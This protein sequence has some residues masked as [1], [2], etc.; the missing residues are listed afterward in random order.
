MCVHFV[1]IKLT[2]LLNLIMQV[3]QAWLNFGT[4]CSQCQSYKCN[5]DEIIRNF[6]FN[7]VTSTFILCAFISV[8]ISFTFALHCGT[9]HSGTDRLLLPSILPAASVLALPA[10]PVALWFFDLHACCWACHGPRAGQVLINGSRTSIV[11][12]CT[13]GRSRSKWLLS[14]AAGRWW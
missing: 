9:R 2:I 11:H 3:D 13:R 8:S 10:R 1:L 12:Y 5:N 14:S 4:I 7:V 6:V